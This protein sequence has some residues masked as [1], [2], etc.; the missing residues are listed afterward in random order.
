MDIGHVGSK[1]V[2]LRKGIHYDLDMTYLVQT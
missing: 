2:M 1:H